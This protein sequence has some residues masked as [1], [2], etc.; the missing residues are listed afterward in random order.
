MKWC[1]FVT[2]ALFACVGL[3]TSARAESSIRWVEDV[4]HSKKLDQRYEFHSWIKPSYLIGDFN[5][6]GRPDVAVPIREQKSGKRGIAIVHGGTNEVS[7]LGA[8]KEIGNAG[9]NFEW[10]DEW[11]LE[12]RQA[13]QDALVVEK[14]E[15]ASA[16]IYWDGKKYKWEQQGD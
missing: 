11:R 12:K 9:D 8:G 16:M 13:K 5:G 3:V 10:M 15:S 4:F 7:I 6:D 14:S 1:R 2:W